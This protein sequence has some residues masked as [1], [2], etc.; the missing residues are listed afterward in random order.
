MVNEI[1]QRIIDFIEDLK[2][3]YIVS[4]ADLEKYLEMLFNVERKI[5]QLLISREKWKK[6]YYAL[7]REYK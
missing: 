7:K 6:K 3:K 2:G 5:E 4:V 1:Q